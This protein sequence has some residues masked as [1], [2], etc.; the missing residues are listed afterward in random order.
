MSVHLNSLVHS[1]PE[2][3]FNYDNLVKYSLTEI[4]ELAKTDD[5]D[6]QSIAADQWAFAASHFGDSSNPEV[7]E[8]GE[9]LFYIFVATNLA[10][11]LFV[12]SY[13]IKNKEFTSNKHLEFSLVFCQKSLENPAF[14]FEEN[15]EDLLRLITLNLTEQSSNLLAESDQTLAL[16]E[17]LI[18]LQQFETAKIILNSSMGDS[19]AFFPLKTVMRLGSLSELTAKKDLTFPSLWKG[20]CGLIK[21]DHNPSMIDK[22]L[23][24]LLSLTKN[25]FVP[26]EHLWGIWLNA[27][28]T[29]KFKFTSLLE[30]PK[31]YRIL[32][33]L[34][35]KATNTEQEQFYTLFFSGCL[36]DLKRKPFAKKSLHQKKIH[37]DCVSELVSLRS[38]P[39]CPSLIDQIDIPL[40]HQLLKSP[41]QAAPC[42]NQ[43]QRVI[44]HVLN[45]DL[46]HNLLPLIEKFSLLFN[47]YKTKTKRRLR[48]KISAFCLELAA[49]PSEKT[50]PLI[51]LLGKLLTPP[52]KNCQKPS[53][54]QAFTSDT[55]ENFSRHILHVLG[56]SK[57]SSD[58]ITN[59]YAQFLQ[60]QE[61]WFAPMA[62]R[63]AFFNKILKLVLKEFEQTRD[64]SCF[65]DRIDKTLTFL[66]KRENQTVLLESDTNET[67]KGTSAS[68]LL[69][70]L[71]HS[72]TA[73]GQFNIDLHRALLCIFPRLSTYSLLNEQ[74]GNLWDYFMCF[75]LEQ[76]NLPEQVAENMANAIKSIKN[77][78]S[79]RELSNTDYWALSLYVN[80]E[81]PDDLRIQDKTKALSVLVNR[82]NSINE[83][84]LYHLYRIIFIV[85][86]HLTLG[87]FSDTTLLDC[88]KTLLPNFIRSYKNEIKSKNISILC[89]QF[90]VNSLCQLLERNST[91]TTGEQSVTFVSLLNLMRHL[92]K[93]KLFEGKEYQFFQ[94]AKK[95]D[96]AIKA[97]IKT[98][99]LFQSMY[100]VFVQLVCKVVLPPTS[101]H[102]SEYQ[103]WVVE[104]IRAFNQGSLNAITLKS[105]HGH[106]VKSQ[107]FR[108]IFE[109]NV[110]KIE[111]FVEIYHNFPFLRQ[112][113][114]ET[115]S[116]P[117][118][119]GEKLEKLMT[120]Q[121]IDFNIW[122]SFIRQV[123]A[124]KND[125]LHRKTWTALSNNFLPKAAAAAPSLCANLW[126]ELLSSSIPPHDE[127]F[128]SFFD[129][130]ANLQPLIT[131]FRTSGFKK[132][133][134]QFYSVLY[135][136]LAH[137]H[138]SNSHIPGMTMSC[139]RLSCICVKELDTWGVDFEGCFSILNQEHSI[140]LVEKM[141]NEML[142]KQKSDKRLIFDI[143]TVANQLRLPKT[144]NYALKTQ[145][146]MAEVLQAEFMHIFSQTALMQNEWQ[147]R[148]SLSFAYNCLP[149]LAISPTVDFNILKFIFQ[150]ST[151][152]IKNIRL[153]KQLIGWLSEYAADQC[154]HLSNTPEFSEFCSFIASVEVNSALTFP[155][156]SAEILTAALPFLNY[157]IADKKISFRDKNT[158][159]EKIYYNFL[160]SSE[161]SSLREGLTKLFELARTNGTYEQR[162]QKECE[163]FILHSVLMGKICGTIPTEIK[164]MK[165]A[166]ANVLAKLDKNNCP[167]SKHKAEL[168][169]K[170]F[171]EYSN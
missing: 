146:V 96:K 107:L 113:P 36:N 75:P 4:L 66:N 110:E 144:D 105:I 142:G 132:E 25:N 164:T 59:I 150:V 57:I 148:A 119:L 71:F 68:L 82:L 34:F 53:S 166:Y 20:A 163:H 11:A 8:C 49:Y 121:T 39:N 93:L 149:L 143:L 18:K 111:E 108:E 31:D 61:D 6:K 133:A 47:I 160:L 124:C 104:W 15:H 156:L 100:P 167:I 41:D 54:S 161:S 62:E 38:Q 145:S 116:N 138:F 99:Y 125:E 16:V 128:V 13:L 52:V 97:K 86:K 73:D 102:F 153:H 70:K 80:Q 112:I 88:L 140:V 27:L 26:E 109:Y 126:I 44:L 87:T 135:T 127:K 89:L 50:Q 63:K 64:Y 28:E 5:P 162:T 79:Q 101:V 58:E 130:P 29:L 141:L 24:V 134:V 159:L 154:R 92:R 85:N 169:T 147:I 17:A 9:Q 95:I 106:V 60:H 81:L 115:N 69:S 51:Q 30:D 7:L 3:T 55:V 118:E 23:V 33:N 67:R 131:L 152:N 14:K 123:S 74:F 84:N 98:S 72:Y 40:L 65:A 12:L 165:K 1:C 48:A 21:K 2:S 136:K 46:K 122:Q 168:V 114:V 77:G 78:F 19:P 90:I 83:V 91:D 158:S 76:I 171:G 170:L 43:L 94:L 129:H 139:G 117:V 10:E 22:A 151:A 42:W 157:L 103:K 155:E 45:H 32:L 35:S 37:L 120:S 137:F 56:K